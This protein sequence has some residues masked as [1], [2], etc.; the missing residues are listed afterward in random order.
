MIGYLYEKICR[1]TN[2]VNLSMTN[3]EILYSEMYTADLEAMKINII[4]RQKENGGM[5]AIGE[6]CEILNDHL[7]NDIFCEASLAC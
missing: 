6:C 1:K 3:M 4:M 2:Y 5:I 7:N